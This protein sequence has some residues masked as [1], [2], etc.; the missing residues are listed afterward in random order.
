MPATPPDWA[1]PDEWRLAR[2]FCRFAIVQIS[3]GV[4]IE[5][6]TEGL[7]TMLRGSSC[8]ALKPKGSSK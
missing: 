4:E 5:H 7:D 3:L 1:G 8:L 2:K 6:C